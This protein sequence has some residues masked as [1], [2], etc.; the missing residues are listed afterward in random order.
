[1]GK[2]S[3]L[4]TT[5]RWRKERLRY[6][7][8]NPICVLCKKTGR[9]TRA[10]IVDHVEPHKGNMELFWDESNWQPL[11]KQCHDSIAQV[12]DDTGFYHGVDIDGNPLDPNHPWRKDE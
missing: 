6:L 4:Y 10:T 7:R 9:T 8:N 3:Q 11:C 2:Y 1:M 12:K 5:T